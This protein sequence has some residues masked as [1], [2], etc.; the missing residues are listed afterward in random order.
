MADCN[1][2]QSALFY[3]SQRKNKPGDKNQWNF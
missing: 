1:F 2:N 3:R